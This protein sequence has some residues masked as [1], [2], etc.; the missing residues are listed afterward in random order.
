MKSIILVLVL[1]SLVFCKDK[2]CIEDKYNDSLS[3]LRE[4]A[5][6]RIDKCFEIDSLKGEYIRIY[7]M[8][9]FTK[10]WII[11]LNINEGLAIIRTSDFNNTNVHYSGCPK[12]IF[13]DTIKLSSKIM[14]IIKDI[15]FMELR[16]V[17][18]SYKNCDYAISIKDGTSMFMQKGNNEFIYWHGNEKFDNK[19][20]ERMN[21]LADLIIK[22]HMKMKK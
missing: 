1:F 6:K 7:K 21:K 9:S 13:L 12:K 15:P 3:V 2:D 18:R 5:K 16:S 19:Y 22:D 4:P 17:E 10:E 14:D 20:Y 8:P 11:D